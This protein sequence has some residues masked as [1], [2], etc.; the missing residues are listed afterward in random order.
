MKSKPSLF[1][2]VVLCV[3]IFALPCLAEARIKLTALPERA[4]TIIRLDNPRAT[5]IQEDRVLTLQKG[6]NKVDFSW[7]GVSI[8]EDS[9]RLDV[10]S[11]P[12]EA[13]LLG[14]SYPPGESAL[15]WDIHSEEATEVTV[16]ISYLLSNIDRIITYKGVSD[17]EE[18]ELNLKSFL[19]IRNF[20]GEDFENALL[21]LEGGQSF[22]RRILHGETKRVLFMKKKA[23][24]IEKFWT[25]DA[26]KLPWDPE[27]IEGNV[28]IP[29]SYRIKNRK[30]SGLGSELLPGGKVRIFQQDGHGGTI[31]LGEDRTGPIP[32]GEE[33]NIWIGDS[34]DIVVTQHKMRQAHINQ[35]R[36]NKNRVVLYD[37]DEI[38][39]ATIENF[40]DRAARLTMIQHIPGQWDMEEC[41]M[42]YVRKD[43]YTLRFDID[44]PAHGK[45]ELKM[46]YHRR[47]LRKSEVLR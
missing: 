9:I 8:D 25:F 39:K 28:G 33:M 27:K 22:E 6:L 45:K 40:K 21:I 13:V 11:H 1:L 24:P 36:N 30:E 31:F 26:A 14:V 19:V 15:V 37:T 41:N 18:R 2:P 20:S 5:L 16:R 23:V 12:Y 35:R 43:A 10:L 42:K 29:A 34:R 38:I 47:N 3:V 32:I 7:K 44:L 4:K 17:K 46:H